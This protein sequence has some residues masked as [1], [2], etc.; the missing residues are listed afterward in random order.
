MK[1]RLFSSGGYRSSHLARACVVYL[2]LVLPCCSSRRTSGISSASVA[3][4]HPDLG[5]LEDRV[6]KS[7]LITDAELEHGKYAHASPAP[8]RLA[9]NMASDTFRGATIFSVCMLYFAAVVLSGGAG[10]SDVS[11]NLPPRN[12]GPPRLP[13]LVTGRSLQLKISGDEVR[14]ARQKAVPGV[15]LARA[16]GNARID[17][18][19]AHGHYYC[20]ADEIHYRAQTNELIL[21]GR[22]S[23]SAIYAPQI[24]EFGLVRVD[25]SRS[26]VHYSLAGR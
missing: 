1:P 24:H 26:V 7:L 22:V 25:L 16:V 2:C 18:T 19:D 17:V 9:L 8:G 4:R 6:S 14:Y 11:L 13:K 3:I 12:E 15:A 10:V 5:L 21:R 20:C 23:V